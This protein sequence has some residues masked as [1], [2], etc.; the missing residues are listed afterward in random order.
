VKRRLALV[1]GTTSVGDCLL[2]MRH[3]LGGQ[4]VDGPALGR[5]EA[6]F[7]A[8]V[9]A[10]HGIAF[11]TGRVGL[12]GVLRALGVGPGDEVLLQAPTHIVVAN[13]IRYTGAR[14]VYAD[15]VP[16]NWN[17][18]LNDAAR[19]ITPATRVLLLQHTFG[20]PASM[21]AVQAFV[22]EHG[23]VLIEDCVHALGATWRKRPVG[24]FGRAAFFSTEETKV[25]STTMGGMV[26][27]DDD[28]MAEQLRR[29]QTSCARPRRWLTARYLLKLMAYHLLTEPRIHRFARATY[30]RLGQRQPL[31]TPTVRSE[32]EGGRRPDYEQRLTNAQAA[33]GLRQL[34]RLERNI[35][36]RRAIAAAYAAGLQARGWR[37]PAIPEG[38]E[39]VW[40]RYPVHV[41]DREAAM[42][43]LAP[44][45][46]VGT[47]FSS[48]LEE[49]VSGKHGDYV[50]GTCPIAEDAA[51][52]LINAPT[53]ERVRPEDAEG[54]AAAL[55]RAVSP[56]RT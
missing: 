6:A 14:P 35:G 3:L 37:T 50:T 25:I 7:A 47:W 24:T 44:H 27:T 30:D 36:H 2:A 26:V 17:I 21:D 16:D 22:A 54:I 31:P 28:A 32:L 4:L 46:V 38:A 41:P 48:V 10:R 11:A 52:H 34:Q 15:C 8:T 49:A 42:R 13:A 53:H 45:T 12:Y 33:I 18:D 56:Q 55:L 43:A 39:P 9:G 51:R 29:F 23:L 40:V 20:V 1:G 19:R 5:Y